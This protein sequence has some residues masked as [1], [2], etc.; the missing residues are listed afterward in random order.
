MKSNLKAGQHN[1]KG[2]KFKLLKCKCCAVFNI[3]EEILNKIM[4]K[5]IKYPGY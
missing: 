4:K 1:L 3:K 5:E 2:K